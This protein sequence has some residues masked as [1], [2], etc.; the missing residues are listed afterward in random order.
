[1]KK[2]NDLAKLDMLNSV[3][4]EGERYKATAYMTTAPGTVS[5]SQF[6][7]LL[8]FLVASLFP[9]D[10][11]SRQ[12][13]GYVGVTDSS[14]YF[15]VLADLNASKVTNTVKVNFSDIR[16][17]KV[18]DKWGAV[19]VT[20]LTDSKEYSVSLPKKLIGTKLKNQSEDA[21]LVGELL[22]RLTNAVA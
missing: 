19:T 13:G 12:H 15:V 20:I 11:F 6:F 16:N 9:D 3:L 7:G 22:G 1:M 2:I 8:G 18:K 10:G 5:V 14:I 17:I 21:T 4:T